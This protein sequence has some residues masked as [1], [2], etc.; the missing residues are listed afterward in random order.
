MLHMQKVT[1]VRPQSQLKPIFK[2]LLRPVAALVLSVIK[3]AE[4]I[5]AQFFLP[6]DT[7]Q[8]RVVFYSFY[9][10]AIPVFLTL[11]FKFLL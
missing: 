2:T 7:W 11:G 6:T 9:F 4:W 1:T 10:V 3:I 5:D 8:M